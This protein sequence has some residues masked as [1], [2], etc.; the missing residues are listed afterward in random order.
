MLNKNQYAC[1]GKYEARI[2]LHRRFS[3]NPKSK[4]VWI[5]E[6]FPK[7]ENLKV[8]ELGCGTGLFW[9]A[10]RNK[11]PKT[12]SIILSDY[13]EGMLETTRS[14]LSRIN[15]NFQYEVVNAEEIAYP[16]TSFD[17]ILANNML[18][19]IEN[20][21]NALSNIH[22]ILK[23]DG[24]FI[25]STMGKNDL[26]ELHTY[27]YNFLESR[28]ISFKFREFPF[29]LDNGL[30]QLSIYFSKVSIDRHDNEL[31]I[32]EVEPVID[33]YVSMNGMYNGLVILPEKH[34][35]AFREFLQNI[36]NSKKVIS[37][38]KDSGIFICMK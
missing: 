3:T 4:Y 27:L 31:H 25:T 38:T 16:D 9:L 13:S 8:L 11:I 21:S 5:F 28:N 1:S 6:H 37:A 23:D 30:E 14:S 33:Y 19:H 20:R 22:R 24:V 35:E 15:H 18:Y 26:Y 29:S 17:I 2:N 36:I 7:K 34:I 32:N 12:W 10:N